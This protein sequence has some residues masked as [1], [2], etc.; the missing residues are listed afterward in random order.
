MELP[1]RQRLHPGATG[2]DS[3]ALAHTA[4]SFDLS[5]KFGCRRFKLQPGRG[6]RDP[7]HIAAWVVCASTG[8]CCCCTAADSP[9]APGPEPPPD[10]GY[11]LSGGG[12]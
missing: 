8:P 4:L 9:R 12:R 7:H 3:E 11:A 2:R 1:K 10:P 5:F 6:H